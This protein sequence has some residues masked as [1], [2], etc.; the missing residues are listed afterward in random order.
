MFMFQMQKMF[1]VCKFILDFI[2][3]ED[4]FEFKFDTDFLYRP[5]R[6]ENIYTCLSYKK[7]EVKELLHAFKYR[8]HPK[9]LEIC[10]VFMSQKIIE[11]SKKQDLKNSII[12][13]IPRSEE[14]VQK[15]GFDQCKKLCEEIIKFPEIKNIGLIYLPD[16]LIHEKEFDS[17]T[18][19]N[20]TQRL[21]NSKNTF[22]IKNIESIAT[23][24]IILI[25]D[26][27]TTG[28]TLNDAQR[29]LMIHGAKNIIKITI[30][31]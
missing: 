23:S 24:R 26:V 14:R 12:I 29:E 19:S 28:A 1:Y 16:T 4:V 25:D 6:N 18:K 7:S 21:L 9:A 17:Q 27:W 30:S 22:Y 20:R 10:S 11:I 2:I 5:N 31:H 8:K 15:F 13:P 3:P